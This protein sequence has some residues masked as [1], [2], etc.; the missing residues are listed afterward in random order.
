M[1]SVCPTETPLEITVNGFCT[2]QLLN[3]QLPSTMNPHDERFAS[4]DIIMA[5]PAG[6]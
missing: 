1:A 3:Q 6:F 5:V 2:D 4:E